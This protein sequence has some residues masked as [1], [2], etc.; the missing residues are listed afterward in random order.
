MQPAMRFR[1]GPM[2]RRCN[3][4]LPFLRR[5]NNLRRSLIPSLLTARRTNEALANPKIELFETAKVYWASPADQANQASDKPGLPQEEWML[6]LTTGDD[7]FA[8]KGIINAMLDLLRPGITMQLKPFN[9][10]LFTKGRGAELWLD[11]ERL[12]FL[13]EV[14]KAGQSQF[15]LRGP[16]TVAELRISPFDQIAELIPTAKEL[17]PFPSV[18]RDINLVVDEQ[19]RW[20]DVE[21]ILLG[22]AGP[23]LEQLQYQETYRDKQRSAQVRKSLLFSLLLRDNAATLTSRRRR[24][25]TR[26]CRNCLRKN[27]WCDATN[28]ICDGDEF[29]KSQL[30]IIRRA[31]QIR[32][33][34]TRTTFQINKL[35]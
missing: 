16:T 24:W 29:K 22:N 1:H 15:E 23:L 5:A 7:F 21:K 14:S 25:C 9:H 19:I 2:P 17:S 10:P 26:Q 13:G 11:D 4:R 34:L 33:H 27:T 20:A 18:A 31:A 8:L 35:R 3:R 32:Y 30:I 6:A 12:G 28:V